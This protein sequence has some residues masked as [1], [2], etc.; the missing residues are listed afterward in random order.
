M[1]ELGRNRTALFPGVEIQNVEEAGARFLWA[2]T[3]R[4][5]E[6]D[7]VVLAAGLRPEN[8]LWEALKDRSVPAVRVGNAAEVKNGFQNIREAF[9]LGREL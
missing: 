8:G 2:G 3:R 9:C 7:T 5:L 1:E 6:A 4:L